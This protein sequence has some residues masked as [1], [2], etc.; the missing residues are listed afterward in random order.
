MCRPG[1]AQSEPPGAMLYIARHVGL[2]QYAYS[3]CQTDC[4]QHASTYEACLYNAL[5]WGLTDEALPRPL[6]R[7]EGGWR[8]QGAERYMRIPMDLTSHNLNS[9][10]VYIMNSTCNI[11]LYHTMT[12]QYNTIP[13][14]MRRGLLQV[15]GSARSSSTD[16]KH[17]CAGAASLAN[18]SGL[19]PHPRRPRRSTISYCYTT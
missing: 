12:T 7:G 3:S 15:P 19:C 10:K 16:L 9:N 6:C 1:P 8:V 2:C 4:K 18:P 17:R 13:I 11:A 14:K 5:P